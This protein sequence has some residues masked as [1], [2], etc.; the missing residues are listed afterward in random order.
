[1]ARS[2]HSAFSQWVRWAAG[3]QVL[4]NT[5]CDKSRHLFPNCWGESL[6]FCL[7]VCNCIKCCWSMCVF[8]NLWKNIPLNLCNDTCISWSSRHTLWNKMP[9]SISFGTT[10]LNLS[11]SSNLPIWVAPSILAN[12]SS[13]ATVESNPYRFE[14]RKTNDRSLWTDGGPSDKWNFSRWISALDSF[15]S[16]R[17]RAS[18]VLNFKERTNYIPTPSGFNSRLVST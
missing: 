14:T 13:I 8:F 15:N 11:S 17:N 5:F 4:H 12:I 9:A 10:I 2:I 1:M 3:L 6:F 7:A 16:A 18:A